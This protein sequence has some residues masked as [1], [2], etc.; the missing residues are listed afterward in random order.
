MRLDS[1]LAMEERSRFSLQ[2]RW[3]LGRRT[4][5]IAA[6]RARID[7]RA[8]EWA[9]SREFSANF[10]LITGSHRSRETLAV[11]FAFISATRRVR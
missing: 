8:R 11:D 4:A 9:L 10:G 5:F 2:N 1:G 7:G 3:N 6:K